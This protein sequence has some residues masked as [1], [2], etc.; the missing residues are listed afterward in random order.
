MAIDTS[1][2]HYKAGR[3]AARK[4]IKL[5]VPR[6]TSVASN[7]PYKCIDDQ[8]GLPIIDFV[9][10]SKEN[11]AFAAGANDETLRAIETGLIKVD[12]RALLLSKR[13]I[14]IAFKKYRIGTLSVDNPNIEYPR[15]FS[16]KLRSEKIR[17]M[18][19]LPHEPTKRNVFI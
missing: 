6:W 9:Q 15:V 1:N 16:V 14:K 5:G 11:E 13:E 18:H 2:E 7:D 19:G 8:T 17:R 4:A 12:F 10:K 3:S